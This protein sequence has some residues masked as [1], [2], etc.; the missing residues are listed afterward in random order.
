MPERL[1]YIYRISSYLFLGIVVFA[2][3]FYQNIIITTKG[4]M[5]DMGN[6]LVPPTE[7]EALLG[8]I[9][10]GVYSLI[11]VVFGTLYKKIAEKQ[12]NDENHRY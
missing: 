1:N 8:N 2:M 4:T 9:Y 11:V 3:V 10:T 5:D 6:I 7:A 12:T